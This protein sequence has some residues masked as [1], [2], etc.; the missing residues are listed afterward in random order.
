MKNIISA[1]F[2]CLVTTSTVE[3]QSVN[4]GDLY[5][6]CI[7]YHN[8]NW[9]AREKSTLKNLTASQLKQLEPYNF[10]A[11]KQRCGCTVT[12]AFKNLSADTIEAYA[13]AL[14]GKGDGIVLKNKKASEEFKKADMMDKNIAC[15]EKAMDASGYEKKLVELAK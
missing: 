7:E 1:L 6:A 5:A 15:A 2:L 11:M 14:N 12:A 3:A 13:Q 10:E 9:K 8:T 4:R